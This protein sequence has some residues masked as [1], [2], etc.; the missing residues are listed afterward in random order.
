MARRLFLTIFLTALATLALETALPRIFSVTMWYHYAFMA[1]SVAMLGMATGAAKVFVSRWTELDENELERRIA[2]YSLY[3]SITTV[4]SLLALL[5]IPFVPRSTGVGIYSMAFIYTIA[6]VPFYFSGVV[7]SAILSTRF[8]ALVNG[9]YAAD[10]AG[11]AVGALL[12]FFF[13]RITD[14]VSFVILIA[15]LPALAAYLLSRRVPTLVLCL[16]FVVLAGANHFERFFRIEWQKVE[17]GQLAVAVET[18]TEW[19]GWTPF[20]RITVS[21]FID[22]AFGWGTSNTFYKELPDYK[23]GQKNLII[24]AAAAT[25][26]TMRGK[27]VEE[28]QHL[29]YD[30]TNLAHFIVPDARVAVIGVGGG[31]DLLSAL[32]F[33]Q[34]E[35][36][37][38]EINERILEAITGPYRDFTY[39]FADIPNVHLIHDEARSFIER[40][41]LKF[42]IIQASL[43]DSWAATASGAF[44]LTENSL[45]TV[46][47]WQA[48]LSKLS[49]RGVVTMSRW[50]YQKRPGE[51]LRLASLAYEAL[52][53]MGVKNPAEHIMLA[54]TIFSGDEDLSKLTK[55]ERKQ[56]E[57]VIFGTGTIIVS[58]RPFDGDAVNKFLTTCERYQFEVL[59]AAGYEGQSVFQHIVDRDKR[60]AMI[61]GYPLKLTAPTDDNPFFFNMLKPSALLQYRGIEK[62]G[63]LNTNLGA[64][65]NLV[66]LLGIVTVLAL[67]LI[68]VPI[69]SAMERKGA[70]MLLHPWSLYFAAIGFGFMLIEIAL[71]QKFTVFLGHPT[72]SLLVVLCT[73]LLFTGFGSWLA[74]RLKGKLKPLHIFIILIA[75]V[76]AAG[77]ANMFILPHL[78]GLPLAARI[79]Y[80]AVVM[81]AIGTVLGMPFPTGMASL[82]GEQKEWGPWLWG[83]NGALGVVSSV[84]ATALSL[85][86]GISVTFFAGVAAYG[87]ALAA[88]IAAVRVKR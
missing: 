77:G 9:L 57:D 65:R 38:I 71:I 72:Y 79:C 52:D 40:T 3:F 70:K 64:V 47:G 22:T 21:N 81:A 46:E 58:M 42:D 20:S 63:P 15:A 18:Q 55:E 29:R 56:R 86:F 17:T 43:I 83:I 80:S 24:D 6:A 74:G 48:F 53:A 16:L 10:L 60:A 19:E 27:P 84:L 14:A 5:S 49:D 73:I 23:V 1:I 67:L 11:A 7:V 41:D 68:I 59:L 54:A 35:V 69:L 88:C 51:L 4:L 50:Y 44:V 62:E 28:L 66:I 39:P 78:S 61:A 13:L 31:R 33:K 34:K 25:I 85:F 37:G 30:I 76:T 8:I 2:R 75:V 36:W 87:L 82:E 26:I 12:F 45:Y 32:H